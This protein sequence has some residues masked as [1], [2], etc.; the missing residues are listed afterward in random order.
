MP[1]NKWIKAMGWGLQ[2]NMQSI[3]FFDKFYPRLYV[4]CQLK[5]VMNVYIPK[6]KK[7]S[8]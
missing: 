5:E 7:P 3:Q 1:Q 6:C 8:L 4:I 2:N